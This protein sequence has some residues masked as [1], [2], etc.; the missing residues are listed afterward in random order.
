MANGIVVRPS[1]EHANVAALADAYEKMQALSESD[2]R[3]WIYWAAFHGF[4]RY[5]CWHNARVGPGTGQLFPY[6]LFLPWH[7]AYLSFFDNAARDQNED[8]ILPWWDWTSDDSHADGLPTAYRSGGEPLQSGPVPSIRGQ[9]ARRTT[10]NPSDPAGLPSYD[11]IYDPDAGIIALTDFRDFSN[12][13]QGVHDGIHGWVGGDMSSIGTS[14]FDPVFWAHHAMIDRIW[15]QWQLRHGVN[16]IPPEYL[17]LALFPGVT[18]QQVLDVHALGFDYATGAVAGGTDV[19]PGVGGAD[20]GEVP[21]GGENSDETVPPT[22]GEP[23]VS[24]PLR[25]GALDTKVYRADIEF[26]EVDHAGAS[27][28]GRVYLNNPD[29]NAD[30]GKEDPSYAGSYNVFGHGGCLGDAG[31]CEVTPRRPYDPRPAHPLTKAK[32]VVIAT[33]KVK[34]AI[35]K[36]D[37]V[38]VCVVPIV[39]PLPY[40]DVDPRYIEKPVD[41]GY[42]RIVT[43]R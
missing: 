30:T 35:A 5:E 37:E 3:G 12:Q 41:I 36:G 8:A 28:E 42:V 23:F 13:L 2:N 31:H 10:R 4:N 9:A 24:E 25:V 22:Q 15:H 6:D 1:A 34:E 18:V 7:R 11:E 40:E 17:N 29:A 16:N 43:Y 39:E 38:T 26:H 33:E 14:A 32:K 20:A 27:Y 21:G 19:P